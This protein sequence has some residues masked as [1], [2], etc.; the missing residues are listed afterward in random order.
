MTVTVRP[1]KW[2]E[3]VNGKIGDAMQSLYELTE[4]DKPEM[5]R[6]QD[7]GRIARECVGSARGVYMVTETLVGLN[8]KPWPWRDA[9]EAKQPAADLVLWRHMRDVRTETQHGE[10]GGLDAHPI[11]ILRG[12]GAD[13]GSVNY[14][15]LGMTPPPGGSNPRKGGVRFSKYP[16]RPASD[17]AREYVALCQRFADDFECDHRSLFEPK[18]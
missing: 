17:V 12:P 11:P 14:V 2:R 3:V 18:P 9:W 10:G 5:N 13:A 15:V 7:A 6:Y 16:D 4:A 1:E 8:Y